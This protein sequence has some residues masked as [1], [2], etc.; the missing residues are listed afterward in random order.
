MLPKN[1]RCAIRCTTDRAAGR[2]GA[3]ATGQSA[4]DS[5]C[6]FEDRTRGG[7]RGATARDPAQAARRSAQGLD[8]DLTVDVGTGE[9]DRAAHYAVYAESVRNLGTPVFPMSLFDA[10]LDTLDSDILTIRHARPS[11]G[12]RS[13]VLPLR[14]RCCY[15]RAADLRGA[16][17]ARQ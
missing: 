17:A 9:D 10:V 13:L 14:A 12:E 16:G 4:A 6:G 3:E 5:H 7:R 2:R 15:C 8:N 11:G 1:W